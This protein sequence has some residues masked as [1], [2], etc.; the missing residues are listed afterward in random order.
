MRARISRG[1]AV[2]RYRPS[3]T[4]ASYGAQL[5]QRPRHRHHVQQGHAGFEFGV[6]HHR[7]GHIAN[8]PLCGTAQHLHRTGPVQQKPH[9]QHP[10]RYQQSLKTIGIKGPHHRDQNGHGNKKHL[11]F[12]GLYCRRP[13]CCDVNLAAHQLGRLRLCRQGRCV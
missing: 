6:E 3:G 10:H 9:G 8:R 13:P 2:C 12:H 7:A 4:S 5:T 11:K 1:L